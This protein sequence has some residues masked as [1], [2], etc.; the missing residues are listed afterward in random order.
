METYIIPLPDYMYAKKIL[1]TLF[2]AKFDAKF[3]TQSCKQIILK[4]L[5][6]WSSFVNKKY[7]L[8]MDIDD[9]D[10]RNFRKEIELIASFELE[11]C[12]NDYRFIFVKD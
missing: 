6:F 7:V 8:V 9:T 2:D 1:K 4:Q 3:Y 10:M 5:S 11:K 12:S